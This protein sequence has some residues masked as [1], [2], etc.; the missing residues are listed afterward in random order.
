MPTI[1]D[2]V[3]F[4]SQCF[5]T[6][7]ITQP[8]GVKGYERYCGLPREA[9]WRTI[10]KRCLSRR[11]S[12]ILVMFTICTAIQ[13]DQLESM[14]QIHLCAAVGHVTDPLVRASNSKYQSNPMMLN[15]VCNDS[16]A[17]SSSS[18]RL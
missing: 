5:V 9:L 16:N 17:S 10:D 11:S 8:S 12:I 3:N 7:A 2:D 4:L 1:V 6:S 18:D 13:C 15:I 14:M